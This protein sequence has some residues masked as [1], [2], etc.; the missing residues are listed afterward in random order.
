MS[1]KQKRRIR[2][3]EKRLE[4]LQDQRMWTPLAG[5]VVE[6]GDWSHGTLWRDQVEQ[7]AAYS[8]YE[9][10]DWRHGYL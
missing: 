4:E 8:D 1:K 2:K 7:Y 10:A 5:N 6:M 9:D 3:L